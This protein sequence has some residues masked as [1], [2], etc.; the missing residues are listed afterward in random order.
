MRHIKRTLAVLTAAAGLTALAAG[1][2]MAAP[3][4]QEVHTDGNWI[5]GE[6]VSHSGGSGVFYQT[7]IVLN[8]NYDEQA[9]LVVVN[10]GS[11]AISLAGSMSTDFQGDASCV[12]S[13]LSPGYRR[14]CFGPTKH[15]H[16]SYNGAHSDLT[17]NG[18]H[19]HDDGVVIYI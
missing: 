2:A 3:N 19:E 12:T 10:D 8:D 9:V 13:V 11:K 4:W 18:V 16:T 6:T 1:P 5:C 7:C 15:A 17:V 14:G